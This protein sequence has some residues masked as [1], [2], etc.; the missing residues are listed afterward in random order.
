[1]CKHD[2]FCFFRNRTFQHF[3]IN[4]ILWNRH[5]YEYRYCA[6]LNQ[7]RHRCR[8]SC[9]NGNYLVTPP[10]SP[11]PQQWRCQSH[12]RQQICRRPGIN[13]RTEPNTQIFCQLCFKLLRISSAGQPEFQGAVY[14]IYH[15]PA[16]I[17][18]GRI[19]NPF[20]FLPA[21][22]LMIFFT[23]RCCLP[24]DAFPCF[25]FRHIFKHYPSSNTDSFSHN[26]RPR[27]SRAPFVIPTVP[28]DI[29]YLLACPSAT[30]SRYAC[31]PSYLLQML[32]PP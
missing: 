25:L 16:V 7:R 30:R 4:I 27:L 28:P 15:F 22:F 11:V 5:I 12:K 29:P 26:F 10:D 1:M 21:L 17:N 31:M 9:R 13:Q 3:N 32:L 6:I 23:I 19:R 20:S 2:S 14:K 8:K 18:T 24:Q